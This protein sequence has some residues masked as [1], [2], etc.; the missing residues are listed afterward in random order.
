MKGEFTQV[1][2]QIEKIYSSSEK[3]DEQIF[4]RRPSYDKIGLG[5]L[6]GEKSTKKV[7]IKK[8]LD[9]VVE[10][11]QESDQSK[12]KLEV[13]KEVVDLSIKHDDP[14][15][16]EKGDK[17]KKDEPSKEVKYEF[18]GRCFICNEVS[19]MKRDCTGNYF[20]PITNY[21]CYNYH[22][23]GHKVVD[24]KKPKFDS[25]NGNSRIFRNTKPAH[26]GRG[27]SQSKFNNGERS[28]RERKHVV[29]YKCKKPGHI[30]RNCRAPKN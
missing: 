12:T 30:A 21:Y 6:I 22:G 4:H 19:H 1:K 15:E 2:Q 20:K 25:Y 28:N 16:I 3:I 13:S 7:E 27:R 17:P 24:C 10:S 5:Y 9:L 8:E 26:N 23:Y 11:P 14:K 29:C 18:R